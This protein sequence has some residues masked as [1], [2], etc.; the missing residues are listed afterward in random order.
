MT[1]AGAAVEPLFDAGPAWLFCPAD[2]PERFAK[3]AAAADVVIVDLEDGVAPEGKDA[4]RAALTASRLDPRRTVVRLNATASGDH[5]RDLDA[6]GRT[7]YRN[8]M[9]AKTESADQVT[10]LAPLRVVALVETARGAVEVGSIVAAPNLAAVMWGAEDLLADLGGSSSRGPDGSYRDVARHLRSTTLLHAGAN[11]RFAVDSVYLDMA[12]LDGL[13][14]ETEDAAAVGFAA[15]PAIHPRQVPVI[16]AAFAPTD[17]EIAWARR[18]LDSS[19]GRPG[20]FEF[21]GRMVD[22]PV[23]R[24]AR[25][26]LAR[27][28]GSVHRRVRT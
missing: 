16:R 9:L 11:R 13:R 1:A 24:H 22:L 8:V 25:R 3:A 14:V 21:E 18:L 12:D 28:G 26:I 23:L 2:R 20:V 10:Q 15:K 4:A 7:G 6:L 27:H 19:A 5:G 17:A